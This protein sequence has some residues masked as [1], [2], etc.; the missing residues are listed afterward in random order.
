[1][2]LQE[3]TKELTVRLNA[4][5][6]ASRK[7]MAKSP[8]LA[9]AT[10]ELAKAKNLKD[11]T[12]RKNAFTKEYES[13]GTLFG[14]V[15]T[16]AKAVIEQYG[17]CK[18]ATEKEEET[19]TY[20]M[21]NYVQF[22]GEVSRVNQ[23]IEAFNKAMILEQNRIKT[24]PMPNADALPPLIGEFSSKLASL[25]VEREDFEGAISKSVPTVKAR[26]KDESAKLASLKFPLQ[27]GKKKK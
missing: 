17:R 11:F 3:D 20:L 9:D 7:H 15:E 26:I 23:L 14:A 27:Q 13:A 1:M 24:H 21:K 25:K 6:D 22:R 10:A 8:K 5:V 12:N 4:F 2:G 18:V 16:A 19:A